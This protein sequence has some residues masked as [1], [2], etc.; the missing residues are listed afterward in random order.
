MDMARPTPNDRKA[1]YDALQ[2]AIYIADQSAMHEWRDQIIKVAN[3]L[4]DAHQ[5]AARKELDSRF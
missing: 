1:L 2:A 4:K 5:R 3:E